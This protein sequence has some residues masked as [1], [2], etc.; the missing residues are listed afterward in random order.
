MAGVLIGQPRQ[1]ERLLPQVDVG[2]G[3]GADLGAGQAVDALVQHAAQ[4]HIVVLPDADAE[5][6]LLVA[7]HRAQL[8]ARVVKDRALGLVGVGIVASTVPAC[9]A[10][11]QSSKESRY[12]T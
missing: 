9:T 2:V 4:Q 1:R 12:S 6:A 8:V 3:D 11:R 7:Q 10:A 5:I